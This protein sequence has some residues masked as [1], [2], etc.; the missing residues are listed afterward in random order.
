MLAKY[1]LILLVL[2]ATAL[3]FVAGALLPAGTLPGIQLPAAGP[4]P[5]A[6]ASADAEPTAQAGNAAPAK[7]PSGDAQAK[8]KAKANEDQQADQAIPYADLTLPN[9]LP[10]KPQL[11]LQIGRFLDAAAAA[12]RARQVALLG[13]PTRLLTV[14]DP[15]GARWQLLVAG[16]YASLDQARTQRLALRRGLGL[17]H[18]PGIL[19]LPPPKKPDAKD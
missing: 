5:P 19:L 6:P 12:P 14:A 1:G 4:T 15:N 8:A 17:R 3:A 11:G 18:P 7:P 2:L 13:Q 9:T 16:P 10:E